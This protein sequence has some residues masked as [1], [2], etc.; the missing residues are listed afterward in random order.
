MTNLLSSLGSA[1]DSLEALL[2]LHL[3]QHGES[4]G[5]LGVLPLCSPPA[6]VPPV[7]ALPPAGGPGEQDAPDDPAELGED[8]EAGEGRDLA[9][10]EG[11]GRGPGPDG[12]G[13]GGLVLVDLE[14]E[15]QGGGEDW[16]GHH[17]GTHLVRNI[18]Y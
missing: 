14:Q 13:D 10:S 17:G 16:Q 15:E 12:E 1:D 7:P 6:S 8:P 5:D 11:Q 2:W 3:S 18:Y 9:G 4:G